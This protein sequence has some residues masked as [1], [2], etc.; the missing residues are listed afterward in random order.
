MA[1]TLPTLYQQFIHLSRYARWLDKSNRRESWEET[2]DRYLDFMCNYQCKGKISNSIKKQLREAIL[3]LEIMPSMRCLMTAGKALERDAVAGYNCSYLPINHISAFDEMMYVLMCGAGVGYSV[4]RQY[5]K[6]D[7]MP[8]IPENVRPSK[9]VIGVEDS[10][11]GWANAFRELLSMLYQGRVPKWD[12]SEVRPA[13]SRLKTFGGRASGPEPLE[14]LFH[15]CVETFTNAAGRRLTSLECH[16]ICCKIAEVVVVGGVRRSAC[17]SLSNPSDDRMRHAKSGNWH[18]LTPW[19]SMSNNSA[20]YTEKPGMEVFMREWLALY[21]S[22]SGERGIF[23]RAAAQRQ[24]ARFGRR[25]AE[26]E[27]GCNPCSEIIIRPNQFCNLTEVVVRLNDNVRSLM[28]K[29]R[30]ATILGTM[31][32]TLT[33]FRYLRPIWRQNTEEERLLGVSLTGV[34]DNPLM[35]G[36]K[37]HDELACALQK[38][39]AQAVRTNKDWA[40][41]LGIPQ[42]A[43]ITCN[44]PSGTVSQ[45]VDCSSGVHG[46]EAPHYLRNVRADKNDPLARMMRELGFPCEDDIMKPE[47]NLVFTFPI[48]SP[49]NA[50]IQ[51]EMTAVEHLNL[52]KAYQ[53]HWCEHKP[54]C[55][56]RIRENE[57]MDVGAWVYGN[58]DEVSGISF[59]PYS[60]HVYRQAPYQECTEKEYGEMTKKL[61]KKVDWAGLSKYEADDSSVNYGELACS[62]GS[63][64]IVDLLREEK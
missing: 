5:V 51:S 18:E 43:A 9:T 62:A 41:K 11:L 28:R 38:L 48:K 7:H 64:E 44:K 24:V 52:W 42:A 20:C 1:N 49:K 26:W 61:P 6:T 63:C 47:H 53:D 36:H 16:D 15:F 8:A 59:L 2:V 22:K 17:I 58:F 57:W 12:T 10:K 56:I 55:T 27:F 25:D 46:R 29:V 31:Q 40:K 34:M 39:R 37:G 23:N 30:L 21:E 54:S 19:R 50:M 3:N 60:G 45:L 4:E 33:K 35:S 14:D 13:G 32:A